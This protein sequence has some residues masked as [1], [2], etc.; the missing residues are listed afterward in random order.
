MNV[1]KNMMGKRR[2]VVGALCSSL[3]EIFYVT[4]EDIVL[5]EYL[6]MFIKTPQTCGCRETP[7]GTEYLFN[8]ANGTTIYV[9]VT[10]GQAEFTQV[11]RLCLTLK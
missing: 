2:C 5:P 4:R 3:Y 10:D 6:N 8:V 7:W 9:T 1:A 11:V